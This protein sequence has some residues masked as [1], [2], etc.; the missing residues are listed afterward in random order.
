MNKYNNSKFQNARV[1]IS[2]NISICAQE[3][4]IILINT[5]LHLSVNII[6]KLYF[7]SPYQFWEKWDKMHLFRSWKTRMQFLWKDSWNMLGQASWAK[8]GTQ[9]TIKAFEKDFKDAIILYKALHYKQGKKIALSCF[10]MEF[11]TWSCFAQ[12]K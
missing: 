9:D 4:F 3:T 6:Y 5:I 1:H 11:S 7:N 12:Q 2:L 10:K 8:T